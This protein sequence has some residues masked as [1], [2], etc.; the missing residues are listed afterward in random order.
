MTWLCHS[1]LVCSWEIRR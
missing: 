1:L